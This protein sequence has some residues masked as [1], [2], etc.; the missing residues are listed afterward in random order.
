[1]RHCGSSLPPALT[2]FF[3]IASLRTQTNKSN[4]SSLISGQHPHDTVPVYSSDVFP[5]RKRSGDKQ[6]RSPAKDTGFVP[7]S[8]VESDPFSALDYGEI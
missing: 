5:R 7:G 2:F 4:P 3:L 6:R 1:M 8:V